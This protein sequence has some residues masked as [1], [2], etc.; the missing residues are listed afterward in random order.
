MQLRK[1]FHLASIERCKTTLLPLLRSWATVL[2]GD[3][4]PQLLLL[5]LILKNPVYSSPVHLQAKMAL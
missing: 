4:S 2:A 5:P 1:H 3:M